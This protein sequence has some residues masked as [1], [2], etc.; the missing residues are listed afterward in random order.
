MFNEFTNNIKI[1]GK[2]KYKKGLELKLK[3]TDYNSKVKHSKE[4]SY[5][6][7]YKKYFHKKLVIK[8][9]ILPNEY[10]L[11]QIEN[12]IKAKYCH[13]LAAFKEDLL[14]NYQYEFLKEYYKANES[15]RIL[16]LFWEFYK[17]YLI[18]FCWP[19]LTELKLNDFI[20]EMIERKAKCFYQENYQDEHEEKKESNIINSIFFTNKIKKDVSRKNSLTDLSKTTIDL[21]SAT[22]KNSYSSYMSINLLVNEIGNENKN[23]HI[24]KI[25]NNNINN[26]EEQKNTN[27][28]IN[29]NNCNANKKQNK[30]NKIRKKD[31]YYY[32]INKANLIHKKGNLKNSPTITSIFSQEGNSINHK[33]I[34]ELK[35]NS[36]NNNN[37]ISKGKNTLINNKSE[38]NNNKAKEKSSINSKP[39][40]NKINIVNNKIII[41]N[42]NNRSKENVLK[43]TKNKIIRNRNKNAMISS[44]N[45]KS[46]LFLTY[47][48][49]TIR[50]T[51]NKDL[52]YSNNISNLI[53]NTYFLKTFRD[54]IHK[55]GCSKNNYHHSKQTKSD[56]KMKHIKLLKEKKLNSKLKQKN[57]VHTYISKNHCS[58]N[59]NLLANYIS[60]YK[61]YKNNNM[62]NQMEF[63]KKNLTNF[64]RFSNNIKNINL[65]QGFRNISKDRNRHF[66]T[67][68]HSTCSLGTS[69]NHKNKTKNVIKISTYKILDNI[70]KLKYS[71]KNLYKK[72]CSKQERESHSKIDTI[73]FN[74][75]VQLL[76]LYKK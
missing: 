54:K 75:N 52:N 17:I 23:N 48:Q 63:K 61:Y 70:P 30:I 60:N 57:L 43:L 14:F 22:S 74:K 72:R 25:G 56:S 7:Q 2:F 50:T 4:S 59:T 16:P 66:N 8:Y 3:K 28:I 65:T 15:L 26:L 49:N 71:K 36:K 24:N 19:I 33:N 38:T 53:D 39:L 13:S 42:N 21:K 67:M 1:F 47:R 76:K 11:M 62:L 68:I 46:N 32:I 18:F 51:E 35:I 10:K 58:T 73:S 6:L 69:T 41:I 9:N 20:K 44:R 34:F 5:L 29:N 27:K 45:I 64:Q 31:I 40:Y 37:N 12:F 55:K